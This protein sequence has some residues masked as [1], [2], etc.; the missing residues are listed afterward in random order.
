MKAKSFGSV[1]SLIALLLSACSSPASSQLT[2]T[3]PAI[4]QISL[5]Q[6]LIG[7]RAGSYDGQVY[8]TAAAQQVPEVKALMDKGVVAAVLYDLSPQEFG[9]KTRELLAG[10]MP[11]NIL[12]EGL[13][14]YMHPSTQFAQ[15]FARNPTATSRF[16]YGLNVPV[17]IHIPSY[18]LVSAQGLLKTPDDLKSV[19][20][21]EAQ[22]AADAYYGIRYQNGTVITR[23]DLSTGAVNDN[24]MTDLTEVRAYYWQLYD[25]FAVKHGVVLAHYSD[26]LV[27]VVVVNYAQHLYGL[28]S[29]RLNATEERLLNAQRSE[30]PGITANLTATLVQVRFQLNGVYDTLTLQRSG[31]TIGQ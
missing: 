18:A 24:F 19:I 2:P 5:D 22:H 27:K 3:P 21:H 23:S 9:G 10:K 13:E 28:E 4:R 6:L 14:Q 26:S 1:A 29:A 8:V 31:S 20:K 25:I 15:Q 7:V 11:E 12:Q 16:I 30:F 17:C